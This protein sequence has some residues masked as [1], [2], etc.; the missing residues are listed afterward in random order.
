MT[1]KRDIKFVVHE[2]RLYGT[3]IVHEYLGK[4]AVNEYRGY[5]SG[6][7]IRLY[8]HKVL[9]PSKLTMIKQTVRIRDTV[10]EEQE[11]V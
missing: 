1:E 4:T 3:L 10:R 6:D 2:Q 9:Q 5:M 11:H 8:P 7:V